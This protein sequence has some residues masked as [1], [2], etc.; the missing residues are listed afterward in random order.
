MAALPPLSGSSSA[1]RTGSSPASGSRSTGSGAG[2]GGAVGADV[3]IEVE[4]RLHG[5]RGD[6]LGRRFD[7][8]QRDVQ[9]HRVLGY[10][11]VHVVGLVG[12]DAQVVA[13][14][15][16][17]L[18]VA[19]RH[20][21]P[22]RHQ[23]QAVLVL[24]FAGAFRVVEVDSEFRTEH[25]GRLHGTGHQPGTRILRTAPEVRVPVHQ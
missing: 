13:V 10:V 9:S 16:P 4:I 17:P 8:A 21:G 6:G 2:L 24:P 23:P 1:A 5:L 22:G 19:A 14:V 15:G 18:V 11:D 20:R 12:S 25:S 7:P 3:Q